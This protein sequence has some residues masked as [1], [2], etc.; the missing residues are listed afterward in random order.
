M[1]AL[2]VRYHTDKRTAMRHFWP[3]LVTNALV[4][5][6]KPEPLPLS[7]L[8]TD[9]SWGYRPTQRLRLP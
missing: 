7:P 6:A 2:L 9:T 4:R 8:E 1:L 5:F 3:Q